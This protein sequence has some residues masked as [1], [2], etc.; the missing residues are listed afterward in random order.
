MKSEIPDIL[1]A[2]REGGWDNVG[3]QSFIQI[4]SDGEECIPG[5]KGCII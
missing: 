2:E 1:E 4:I 3:S 5:I